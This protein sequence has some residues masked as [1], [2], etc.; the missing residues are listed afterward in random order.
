MWCTGGECTGLAGS[1][2]NVR[3]RGRREGDAAVRASD[4]LVPCVREAASSRDVSLYKRDAAVGGGMRRG[5]TRARKGGDKE[6][7]EGVAV[8]SERWVWMCVVVACD[9]IAQ[10]PVC[11]GSA[12]LPPPARPARGACVM[13][14]P[15]QRRAQRGCHNGHNASASSISPRQ[16]QGCCH[17]RNTRLPRDYHV[18]LDYACH[19][20][21]LN[22]PPRIQNGTT[23]QAR[24]E[25]HRRRHTQRDCT[26]GVAWAACGVVSCC[27]GR[28]P[29][30]PL[31]S[32]CFSLLLILY[33]TH[34]LSPSLSLHRRAR[35]VS[36][37]TPFTT[38]Y[39]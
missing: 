28:S 24:R 4:V 26:D 34:S 30:Y 7:V 14:Q 25:R 35:L 17:A 1:A 22:A 27:P 11:S 23:A 37:V 13:R 32:L 15:R 21:P 10:H 39:I 9:G 2:A 16:A 31:F 19:C 18:I 8:L 12:G 6:R 29:L 3:K 5:C 36:S 33:N 38:L 20:Q